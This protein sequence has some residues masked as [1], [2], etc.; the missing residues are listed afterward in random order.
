MAIEEQITSVC[1]KHDNLHKDGDSFRLFR[2]L[3]D[4]KL[5]NLENKIDEKVKT[6]T[7][8]RTTELKNLRSELESLGKE[9]PK[10]NSK[11]VGLQLNLDAA[12]KMLDQRCNQV[13]AALQG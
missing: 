13:Q 2:Q 9:F 3:V 12:S 5:L 6:E 4:V 10:A 7:H 1:R 11:I 8:N